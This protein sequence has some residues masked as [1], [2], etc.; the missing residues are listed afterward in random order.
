MRHRRR[1]SSGTDFVDEIA[2]K[3]NGTNKCVKTDSL[4]TALATTTKGAI[5]VWLSIVDATPVSAGVII[6]F[7][8]TDA[9]EFID[10]FINT[11]GTLSCQVRNPT[12]TQWQLTTT[13][14]ALVSG[15][16]AHVG[17][18]FDGEAAVLYVG[19][20]AVAQ[21]YNSELSKNK[22]MNDL[23]GLDN[24]RIGCFNKNSA[25]DTNHLDAT[26]NEPHYFKNNIGAAGFVELVNGGVGWDVRKHSKEDDLV[27][28]F[29]FDGDLVGEGAID[30]VGG[31][32]GVYSNIVQ[33]DFVRD[34]NP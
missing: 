12:A 14:Q 24:G 3:L 15:V 31:N 13:A 5:G 1:I 33:A 10:L 28:G 9:N 18:D 21:A 22:W 26:V 7:G 32:N 19:G 17:V 4:Q 11:N 2:L 6:S 23:T 16:Y 27:S 29:H 34:V 30:Y 25:G 20:V 8:N